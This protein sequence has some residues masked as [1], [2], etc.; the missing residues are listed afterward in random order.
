MFTTLWYGSVPQV[1]VS[2]V[3][4]P[5]SPI[6]SVAEAPTPVEP[7]P[8]PV[9]SEVVPPIAP[10]VERMALWEAQ[11]RVRTLARAFAIQQRIVRINN[12]IES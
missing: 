9:P 10:F 5:P 8:L 1:S 7:S 2:A 12:K 6:S 11:K 4:E 3:V